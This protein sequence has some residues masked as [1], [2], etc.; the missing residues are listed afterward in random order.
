MLDYNKRQPPRLFSDFQANEKIPKGINST[1]LTLIPKKI[2]AT[3]VKDYRAISLISG[4]YKILAEVLQ[5]RTRKVLH[6]AIDG[7]QF[8][9]IKDRNIMDCILT[10]KETVEDYRQRKKK[11][12]LLKLI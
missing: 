4:P 1:F 6:E 5:N 10:V 8:A 11:S 12:L 2:G 7:N 9:F 3:L